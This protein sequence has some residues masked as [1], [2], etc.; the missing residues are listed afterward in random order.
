MTKESWFVSLYGKDI[1]SSPNPARL[2]SEP[3][4]PPVQWMPE[5]TFSE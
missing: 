5:D 4:H 3:T 1:F 2:A